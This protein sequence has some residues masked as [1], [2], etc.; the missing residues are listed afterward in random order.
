MS[1]GI[2][3]HIGINSPGDCT[4]PHDQLL[5][6][7][8]AAQEMAELTKD[9]FEPF[10][11]FLGRANKDDVIE[12]IKEAK[13]QLTSDGTLLLTF[14]GHGCQVPDLSKPPE[15]D[16]FDESWCLSDH[17]L[18]DDDID[19]LLADF[20]EDQRIMII[21]ESCHG[22]GIVA[23]LMEMLNQLFPFARGLSHAARRAGGNLRN[24]FTI[25]SVHEPVPD[26]SDIRIK[27]ALHPAIK[28]HVL[29]LAACREKQ[30]SEDGLF[31]RTLLDLMKG[32]DPPQS[33][34][35]LI[36]RAHDIIARSHSDQKPG[37]A[38]DSTLLAHRPFQVE[39]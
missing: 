38:F 17:Q 23:L 15:P 9:R 28:A 22:G 25:S 37:W 36:R 3:I 2:A 32:T 14:A 19:K 24:A 34:A 29:L 5:R 27:R 30:I 6:C 20:T 4:C 33:Y 31:T 39:P 26:V 1:K 16:G 12:A 7:V 10:G 13:K 8:S 11:S 21:S 18:I 35:A